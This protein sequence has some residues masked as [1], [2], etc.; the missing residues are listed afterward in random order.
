MK[1]FWPLNDLKGSSVWKGSAGGS[2]ATLAP[3]LLNMAIFDL[4]ASSWWTN[5]VKGIAASGTFCLSFFKPRSPGKPDKHVGWRISAN[6]G[7]R[8]TI[9]FGLHHRATTDSLPLSE[10]KQQRSWPPNE[11]HLFCI[12]TSKY[13]CLVL[14]LLREGKWRRS[15]DLLTALLK[16]PFSLSPN[17][18][19]K[20]GR[21]LKLPPLRSLSALLYCSMVFVSSF[22]PSWIS[23]SLVRA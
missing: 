4:K 5:K 11:A 18:S 6:P 12:L 15:H 2:F 21:L 17:P 9:N 8:E 3:L 22:W 13:T 20:S 16:P 10:W 14:S 23:D 1:L 19:L 7:K